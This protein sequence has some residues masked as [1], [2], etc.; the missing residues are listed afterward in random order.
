M[1]AGLT[2]DKILPLLLAL[3][4]IFIVPMLMRRYGL[5]PEDI[6]RRLFGGLKKQGYAGI[7]E[8]GK[9]KSKKREP[10]QTNGRSADLK[11]L[12]ST[13]LILAR[14]NGFGLVYPGTVTWKGKTAGLLALIVTR[15]EVVGINCF[16]FGGTISE[17][18]GN[19]KQHMNGVDQDIPDPL[20]GNLEQ[21]SIVRA[22]MDERG[23]KEI[24]LSVAAV[25]TSHTLTLKTKHPQQVMDTEKLVEMLK[26][27]AASEEAVIDPAKISRKINAEVQRIRK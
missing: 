7:K 20:K 19:W 3:L 15:S 4:L 22:M 1:T 2:F 16:G 26:Q 10:W 27:K 24:P 17:E 12:V 25:F 21:F 11:S 14:R 18:G 5:E 6:I 8:T 13:L 9:E 23:M